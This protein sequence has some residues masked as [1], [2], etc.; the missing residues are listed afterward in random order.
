[1]GSRKRSIF[2]IL[3][4]TL[5]IMVAW[6][7]YMNSPD[8]PDETNLSPEEMELRVGQML[9]IQY[10]ST[11]HLYPEPD[12]LP[13]DT[14]TS[15]VLPAMGPKMGIFRHEVSLELQQKSGHPVKGVMQLVFVLRFVRLQ[16]VFD[17]PT[18]S[19]GAFDYTRFL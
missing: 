10:C 7:F 5:F 1:M 6:Y 11:C 9:S 3:A 19:V 13:K 18:S 17:T 2:L 16:P 12:L 15:S 14:W 4:G 8:E